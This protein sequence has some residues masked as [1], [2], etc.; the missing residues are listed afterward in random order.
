MAYYIYSVDLS[1]PE[2]CGNWSAINFGPSVL[3]L[4]QDS[5]PNTALDWLAHFL[6]EA[7]AM[8]SIPSTLDCLLSERW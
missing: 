6:T 3:G 4:Q 2:S 1:N 7:V 5:G 8:N